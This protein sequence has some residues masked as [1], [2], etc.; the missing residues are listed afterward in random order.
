MHGQQTAREHCAWYIND[1]PTGVTI[2]IYERMHQ[3]WLNVGVGIV[4]GIRGLLRTI[5][6]FPNILS[7]IN[8]CV[9]GL[10]RDAIINLDHTISYD[11][12]SSE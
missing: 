5:T 12:M 7:H 11:K 8:V 3:L 9:P 4:S 10:F 2:V 1:G 6:G